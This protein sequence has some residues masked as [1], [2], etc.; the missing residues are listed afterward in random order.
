MCACVR[1]CA[2]VCVC[3]CVF[4]FV[5]AYVRESSVIINPTKPDHRNMRYDNVLLI[6]R[7]NVATRVTA[8]RR[9][10][11]LSL[12]EKQVILHIRIS[13]RVIPHRIVLNV[14]LLVLIVLCVG[15]VGM[16]FYR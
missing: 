10:Q 16:L 11:V 8:G 1:V 12:G 7:N 9:I 5:C 13:I 6:E 2:Y 15:L 4:V 3:V 14:L